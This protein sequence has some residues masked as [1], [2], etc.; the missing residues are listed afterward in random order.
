MAHGLR[1]G[2]LKKSVPLEAIPSSAYPA[3]A[4]RPL[5]A[6]LAGGKAESELDFRVSDWQANLGEFFREKARLEEAR[7]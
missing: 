1:A 2:L 6:V 3:R 4:Q 5:R 7:P